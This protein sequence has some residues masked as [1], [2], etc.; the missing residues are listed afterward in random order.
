LSVK[1]PPPAD[2]FDNAA[3]GASVIRGGAL[4]GGVYLVGIGLSLISVPLMTRHLGT[5]DYGRVLTVSSLMAVV[6]SITNGGLTALG[7]R[8][9]AVRPASEQHLL[10]RSIVG[11]RMTLTLVG[12]A[13]A[14]VFVVAVGYPSALVAG[15]FLAG[16][17]LFVGS[18]QKVLTIPLSAS[19]RLATLARLSL[20]EQVALVG[21]VVVLVTA[22]AGL[23]PFFAMYLVSGLVVLVATVGFAGCSLPPPGFDRSE[24]RVLIRD[25][26]PYGA[27]I[28]IS[29]TGIVLVSMPLLSTDAQ[30]GYFA[31]AAQVIAI[32]LGVWAVVSV[33]TLPVL[34]HAAQEDHDRLRH[35]FQR[36]I[37]VALI[38][39]VGASVVTLVGAGFAIRALGGAEF[40][41]AIPA[42]QVLAPSLAVGYLASVWTLTLIS[43]RRPV[44][45]LTVNLAV[46]ALTLALAAAVVPDHGATGGA[47]A[48][49]A[50][51]LLYVPAFTIALKRGGLG[52]GPALRIFGVA[53]VAACIAA[54]AGLGVPA[55]EPVSV[56]L[57]SAI[58]VGILMI[59]GG[60]PSEILD[61]L[62]RGLRGIRHLGGP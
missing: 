1:S 43:L 54:V 47:I 30:V 19:L 59:L 4:R 39:G 23:A 56:V 48:V 10:L 21:F 17:G 5:A 18:V 13:G 27:A 45:V 33:S 14:C 6:A 40:E 29:A 35:V 61:L 11:L 46:L 24:W 16:A 25:M 38:V 49:L 26:L 55:P 32:L 31:I 9:Y 15:T 12:I 8:E 2:L 34:A 7:I 52:L 62:P 51:Q 57:S 50:G 41:P 53:G 28:A 60:I 36:T 20:V 44:W 22:G 58:Y 42:L 37:H 3:V